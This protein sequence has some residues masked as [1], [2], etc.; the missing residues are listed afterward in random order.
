MKMK[1]LAVLLGL[2]LV[3]M[4]G[5]ARHMGRAPYGAIDVIGHR[6]ASAYAPE[7]TMAS[8]IKAK[9]MGADWFELD[10]RLS[11]DGEVV[12]M[13]DE[14]VD[15]TTNGSGYVRDMTLHELKQLD[16]GSW[17]GEEF[18]GERVPTLAQCLDYAKFKIGVYVEIKSCD[19]DTALLA[20]AVQRAEGLKEADSA[21]FDDLIAMAEKDETQN[22]VLT[23]KVCDLVNR[24]V[25]RRHVVI[26]SFSPLVCGFVR[27]EYPEL[28]VELLMTDSEK[29][30][31]SWEEYER[32][33]YLM[34]VHGF[35]PNYQALTE[36]RLEAFQ[37]AG[38]SVSVYTVNELPDMQ[39]LCAWGVD[40]II[41]DKPQMALEQSKSVGRAGGPENQ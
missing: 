2:G 36:G 18:T 19:D 9:E 30:A 21:Y 8:F 41:S 34:K 40:G 22:L 1:V 6:G 11:K 24:R 23:R 20:Q 12:V 35:N 5:C 28:R 37:E 27:A 39:R 3:I 33:G 16:A 25:M 17:K 31:I 26:Q 32:L 38:K 14:T 29:S 15:R 4:S 13:H 10:V 7:N